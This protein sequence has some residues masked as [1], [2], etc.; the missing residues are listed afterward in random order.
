MIRRSAGSKRLNRRSSTR[1]E[2]FRANDEARTE[3]AALERPMPSRISSCSWPLRPTAS[4]RRSTSLVSASP[5]GKGKVL[6]ST[7][8]K[9]GSLS[10]TW[11][12]SDTSSEEAFSGVLVTS[13]SGAALACLTGVSSTQ[14]LVPSPGRE[15]DTYRCTGVTLSG[16]LFGKEMPLS[17]LTTQ[18][19]APDSCGVRSKDLGR[20][21]GLDAGVFCGG[22]TTEESVLATAPTSQG[23]RGLGHGI[24]E[25]S[26]SDE[27]TIQLLLRCTERSGGNGLQEREGCR[28]RAGGI[29]GV[30]VGAEAFGN[31][32]F[33]SAALTNDGGG[34]SGCTL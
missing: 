30:R 27:S 3:A 1:N 23:E 25:R 28:G 2:S 4:R 9:S 15:P 12:T 7:R 5:S 33:C 17:C 16:R 18:L 11:R 6:R 26:D 24:L 21:A 32:L 10:S 8:F 20:F 29:P 14:R 13:L 19:K 22:C 31:C 34:S